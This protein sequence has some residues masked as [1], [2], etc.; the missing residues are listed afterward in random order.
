MP[1]V[2]EAQ[3]PRLRDRRAEED[4]VALTA[5]KAMN[6]S[7]L[8]PI[9]ISAEASQMLPNE[10]S[11]GYV[12]GDDGD[13]R[14]RSTASYEPLAQ[15]RCYPGFHQHV[16]GDIPEEHIGG[17]TGHAMATLCW[18]QRTVVAQCTCLH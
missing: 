10:P 2:E 11:V 5:L 8:Y 9:S 1:L 4:E 16:L 17:D 6:G 15:R 18:P 13:S 3:A 12:W 7:T 14:R